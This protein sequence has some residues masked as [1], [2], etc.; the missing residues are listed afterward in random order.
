MPV[1][2]PVVNF[3]Y[4]VTQTTDRARVRRIIAD[5][6]EETAEF[7]DNEIDDN[8]TLETTVNAASALCMEQL[9]AKYARLFNVTADGTSLQLRQ[10]FENARDMAKMLRSRATGLVTRP[11]VM[12]DGYSDTVEYD[13]VTGVSNTLDD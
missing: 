1:G 6:I 7:D 9:A 3:T 10:K 11:T 5:T 4:E 8:L 2:P 12:V 13:D